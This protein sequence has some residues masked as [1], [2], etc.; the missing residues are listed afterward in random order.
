MKNSILSWPGHLP[1]PNGAGP[2]PAVILITGSGAQNRNEE[3]MGHKP[4]LV[5]ADYL[6]RNGIAVL[7]YDDRG[8]GKSQGNSLTATSA[9]LA[10]DAEAAYIFLKKD[11]RINSKFIRPCRP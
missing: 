11:Q 6:T 4:F 8:V 7:R 10:T 1:F 3:I 9:D 5:I 2:F